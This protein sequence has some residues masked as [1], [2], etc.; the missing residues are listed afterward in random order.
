MIRF[1]ATLFVA[2][3]MIDVA[4]ADDGVAATPD[5]R[6]VLAK[7]C[8]SCHGPAK[9]KAGLRLDSSTAVLKG[10][11]SGSVVVRGKSKESLLIKALTGDA[12]AP[13]MPPPERPKLTAVEI[14][15]VKSWI[16]AGVPAFGDESVASQKSD[17]WAFQPIRRPH[18]PNDNSPWNR[19]PID[20]FILQRLT[21]EN[22]TPSPDADRITLLRRVSLDLTGL[23]PTPAE[24]DAFLR[25]NRLDAYER[26][27]TRLLNSPHYGERWA[28]H[29]LDL[30]RYADSNGFTIDGPRT[31]WPYR[32]WVINA[33]NRD[34]PIDQF[35]VEQLAG[36][37]LPQATPEQKVATG[38]HR[39][40]LFNQE[41]GIDLE[42]FRVEYVMDRVATTGT[43]FLGLTVGCAQCHNHKYDPISQGEYY[44]MFAF[45]NNCDEP[46]LTV[47]TPEETKRN[48]AVKADE[49]ALTAAIKGYDTTSP[50]KQKAWE[51]SLQPADVVRIF[52]NAPRI[53]V[54]VDKPDYQRT[55]QEADELRDYL[56]KADH[57][58]QL[59]ANLGDPLP[60]G[61][62]SAGSFAIHERII[63][64]RV[65]TEAKLA[66]LRKRK[67]EGAT[68]LVMQERKMPRETHLLIKGDFTRKGAK[69]SPGTPAVLHPLKAGPN[70]NRLDFAKWIV[71]P[72][73]PLTPRVLVNRVWQVYFGLGLVET[74]NDFG[75]Q[76][77]PPSHPELLDW[78]ADE[79]LRQK[80]SLKELHRTIVTSSTYRQA[81][82]HREG[83]AKVD[84]RNRWLGRQNR[85]RL[86]AEVVR[87]VALV[88]SGLLNPKIGGP[89]VFPPQPDGVFAFTQTQ[90]AWKA[91]AGDDRYR[92]GLYTYFWR[93]APHPGLMAFDAPD[94]NTACT[95]RNRSN[96]PLQALTLL[97]DKAFVEFADALAKRVDGEPRS[98]AKLR[99]AFQ[100]CLGREPNP[101]EAQRLRSALAEFGDDREAWFSLCRVLLNLDEFITRE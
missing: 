13:A 84:P 80:W 3:T 31:I 54:L 27:V 91:D 8:V 62:A 1:A 11:D 36:D 90:R 35:I 72:A 33:L 30:A 25:D 61:L 57:I 44:K 46:T 53:R 92:R 20:A 85:L 41:G 58:P 16:D 94:A 69:M 45:F 7:H 86:D 32:D 50:A 18:V 52:E 22:L 76:G 88:A 23:P 60:G 79:F 74:E 55:K 4:V 56:R 67:P 73:N 63:R 93:S 82:V 89:S 5:V 15:A 87:D 34:Q 6:Q 17:H 65:D 37:M 2:A 68:T 96:T 24:V 28:R 66:E 29:W 43:V 12:D 75:V 77:S 14:A 51:K 98:D 42:M 26:V 48:A 39:N 64:L 9:Q 97:N 83:L 19:N 95:R 81:S 100:W 78:L 40:T 49:A 59:L 70:P 99:V 101:R 21:K 38:F 47:Y 71:D 10:S